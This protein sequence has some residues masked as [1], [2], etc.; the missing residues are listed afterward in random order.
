MRG[1]NNNKTVGEI[2]KKLMKNPNLSTKLDELDALEAWEEILGKNLL[3]FVTQQK[4][5]KGKLYVKLKSAPLKNEL[6]YKKSDLIEQINKK[7]GKKIIKEII[8]Q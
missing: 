8:L 7:I 1:R 3:C 2:I 4:L 6:S 5:Y